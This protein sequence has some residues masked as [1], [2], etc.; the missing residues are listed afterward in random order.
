MT[1][2][3]VSLPQTDFGGEPQYFIGPQHSD[4]RDFRQS[5]GGVLSARSIQRA[6]TL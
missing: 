2:T 3:T 6:A 4:L 5:G 1:L